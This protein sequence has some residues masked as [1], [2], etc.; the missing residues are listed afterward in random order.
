[1]LGTLGLEVIDR[2]HDRTLPPLELEVVGF[3]GGYKPVASGG[4][5][6]KDGRLEP[7]LYRVD[8]VVTCTGLEG[9]LQ[10][11]SYSEL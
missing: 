2:V 1:M 4:E 8:I 11:L 3:L 6:V 10:S 7:T 9:G 5:E